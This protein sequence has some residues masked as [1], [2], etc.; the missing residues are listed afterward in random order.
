LTIWDVSVII[1]TSLRE[2]NILS[3]KNINL[4]SI[5]PYDRVFG[6]LIRPEQSWKDAERYR[7][8]PDDGSTGSERR[9]C[10]WT[11]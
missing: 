7:R 1:D 10:R 6:V 8:I 9:E 11:L 4:T 3:S 2:K 5:H